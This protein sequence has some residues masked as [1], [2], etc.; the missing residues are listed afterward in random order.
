[1]KAVIPVAG[2]GTRLQPFTN[3]VQKCLLP[4]AGKPVLS[5]II[6]PLISLGIDEITM[7]T[8]HLGDQVRQFSSQVSGVRFSFREQRQRMG[9]GHAVNM[10]LEKRDEPVLIILGDSIFDLDYNEFISFDENVIGVREVDDPRRFGV[11]EMVDGKITRLVEKPEVPPSNLAI[12]GIYYFTSEGRLKENIDY[13]VENDIRTRNEYQLT[14]AMQRMLVKGDSFKYYKINQW[15][16]CGLPST[17]LSTNKFLLKEVGNRISPLSVVENSDLKFCHIS[18]GCRVIDS[19]LENV[20][21]LEDTQV[22]NQS[23][24]NCIVSGEDLVFG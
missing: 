21:L 7:I 16:D 3:H 4:V 17:L 19:H 13:L 8:G 24:S 14:D 6:D 5:H 10:A 18:A 20:I 22:E 23:L 1:M 9:L 15:L 12:A 2:H 11:I